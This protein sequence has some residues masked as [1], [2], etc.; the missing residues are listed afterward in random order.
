MVA[1]QTGFSLI[2]ILV[3]VIIMSV[4]ML[5]L[6]GMQI[7]NVKNINN[8]Q[9]Q[10]LATFYAYDMADRIRSNK[11]GMDNGDYDALDGTEVDPACSP[12]CSPANTAQ[13]HSFQLNSQLSANAED[14]GLPGVSSGTVT[15]NGDFLDISISWQQDTQLASQNLT[16]AQ[17]LAARD[18]SF[19]LRVRK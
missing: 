13:L 11:A 6:V 10:T 3:T 2:E 5:G 7:W 18:R 8:S 19:V 9:Y 12:G 1:R 14:G 15:A 16:A 4:G 17:A